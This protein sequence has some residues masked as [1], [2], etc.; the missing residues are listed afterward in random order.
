MIG[1]S[2][3]IDAAASLREL[4]DKQGDTLLEEAFAVLFDD[5]EMERHFRKSLKIYK[6]RRNMFCQILNLTLV[7]R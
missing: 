5:G 4:I 6:Q 1:P 3:F 2:A 7:M